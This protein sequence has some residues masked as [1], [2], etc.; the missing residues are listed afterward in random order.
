MNRWM[1]FFRGPDGFP[2]VWLYRIDTDSFLWQNLIFQIGVAHL[3]YKNIFDPG[4]EH[5]LWN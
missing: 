2:R 5:G 3:V 1:L 4:S